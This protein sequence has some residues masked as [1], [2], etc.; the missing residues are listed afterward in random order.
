[1]LLDE[2]KKIETLPVLPE[3]VLRLQKLLN[4]DEG[5]FHD[6]ATL[7]EQDVSLS[8]VVLKTANSA[9]FNYSGEKITDLSVAIMRIGRY[10]LERVILSNSVISAFPET[11][12]V[13]LH[14]LWEQAFVSSSIVK[15]LSKLSLLKCDIEKTIHLSAL[16]QKIGVVIMS[17]YF[18]ETLYEIEKEMTRSGEQFIDSEKM[19]HNSNVHTELGSSLL[20]LWNLS[21]DIFIPVH[22]HLSPTKAPEKYK[23]ASWLLNAADAVLNLVS[24][25]P[26]TYNS[27]EE[28]VTLILQQCGVDPSNLRMLIEFTQFESDRAR[29]MLSVWGIGDGLGK[30]RSVGGSSLLRPI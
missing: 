2:L 23:H 13:N 1:M 19:I 9:L 30:L 27:D 7:L 29:S 16:F 14:L 12:L 10:E 6:L 21:N 17:S 28:R 3:V 18:P 4:D 20:E 24:P 8:A 5:N 22:F 25:S 26:F 15:K 11:E